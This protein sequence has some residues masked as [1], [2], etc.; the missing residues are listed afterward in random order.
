MQKPL[1]GVSPPKQSQLTRGDLERARQL[2]E[3]YNV[4]G[5]RSNLNTKLDALLN[6]FE[7]EKNEFHENED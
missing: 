6:E 4:P 3:R 1:E 2:S 5:L 7:A